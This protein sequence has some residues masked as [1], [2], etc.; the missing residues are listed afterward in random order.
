MA[1]G[2]GAAQSGRT[3][4]LISS[5]VLS[6]FLQRRPPPEPVPVVHRMHRQI[7]LQDDHRRRIRTMPRIGCFLQAELGKPPPVGVGQ[8]ETSTGRQGLPSAP[9]APP[10]G[11]H[12]P[13]RCGCTPLELCLPR[14][15]QTKIGLFLRAPPPT[16]KVK[17]SRVSRDEIAETP[18]LTVVVQ[19]VHVRKR[20]SP[21]IKTGERLTIGSSS[22]L[23]DGRSVTALPHSAY[24]LPR[25]GR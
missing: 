25:P 10:A 11:R 5:Q 15:K 13:T 3:S 23:P 22:A 18:G 19:Q 17:N 14:S 24:F 9:P 8:A 4:A 6:E 7:G 21:G 12:S 16:E 1:H 2:C 20:G